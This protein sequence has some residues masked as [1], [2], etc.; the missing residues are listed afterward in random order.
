MGTRIVVLS[1]TQITNRG[2]ARP[3]ILPGRLKSIVIH[4]RMTLS[5]AGLST[6]ALDVIRRLARAP[7][8]TNRTI[9]VLLAASQEHRGDVD[10]LLC[11]HEETEAPRLIK[12]SGDRVAEGADF[13]WI[14]NASSAS[15]MSR[16]ELPAFQYSRSE[17][18]FSKQETD[19]T[20]RFHEYL[21]STKN[22]D[23]GG[24]MINCLCSPH[25]HCYQ[26]RAGAMTWNAQLFPQDDEFERLAQHKTGASSFSYHLYSAQQRGVPVVGLYL[27]QPGVGYLYVPLEQDE[28]LRL[29][30]G[31]QGQFRALVIAEGSRR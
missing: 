23:V 20:W 22:P 5:Y 10:F 4:E 29:D 7:L 15:E 8:P 12:I 24:V 21:H 13:Y 16:L 31:D 19:F 26:D 2:S 1:D 30:A 25:G 28:A 27:E 18:E 9:D 17:S 3:N 14:G 11:S 6:Q